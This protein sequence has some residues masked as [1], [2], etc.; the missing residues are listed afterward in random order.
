MPATAY[1][2]T[3]RISTGDVSFLS[4]AQLKAL[5][6]NGVEIGSHTVHHAELPSL[7]DPAA[8]QELIQSRRRPRAPPPPSRAVVRI[9]GGQVQRADARSSRARPATCSQS[10]RSPAR[11]SDA[12]APVR[13]PPLRGA[14]HDRRPRARGAARAGRVRGQSRRKEQQWRER[15]STSSSRRRTPTARSQF[16]N[17][18][19]GWS[20][21]DS[22]MPGMD[23]RMAQTSEAS[24][25]AIFASEDR[26]G[27]PNYYFATDDI[28]A[29]S[30]GPRARRRRRRRSRRSRATAGSPPA[31]TARATLSTSGSRTRRPARRR[32]RTPIEL[33]GGAH[34]SLSPWAHAWSASIP[35][36]PHETKGVHRWTRSAGR[37]RGA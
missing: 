17:G 21:Q 26:S 2:I 28:D 19:F 31:T 20:F 6:Q 18:L 9:P 1:V 11:R 36:A 3:S 12:R 22:G 13:A 15:S 35:G 30:E 7:S 23:Y 24:G 32:S 37:F 10:P 34:G 4:W 8:L 33:P 5:E 14:R 27:Y 29:S 25:A 16:W